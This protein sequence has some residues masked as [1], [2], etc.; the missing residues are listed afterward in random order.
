MSGLEVD[1]GRT[2]SRARWLQETR[3]KRFEE[4]YEG[5]QVGRLRQEEA[6]RLLGVCERSFRR[7]I[8]RYHEAVME[9]LIDRGMA[10]ISG[11]RA[12]DEVA[13]PPTTRLALPL[14]MPY[15]SPLIVRL[16]TQDSCRL[17]PWALAQSG[18]ADDPFGSGTP[19]SLEA[20]PQRLSVAVGERLWK[21]AVLLVLMSTR[22]P[23]RNRS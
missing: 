17:K 2:R 10:Q 20:A 8:D 15:D 4:A 6:A 23:C 19:C 18:G 1:D 9:G 13:D 11:Q 14:P 22:A 12:A 3:K 21:A 5:W 7:Y 16:N